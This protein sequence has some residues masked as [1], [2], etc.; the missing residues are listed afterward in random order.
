MRITLKEK[1]MSKTI[2]RD[3][4]TCTTPNASAKIRVTPEGLLLT[5]LDGIG[6][7][8][9]TWDVQSE[10]VRYRDDILVGHATEANEAAKALLLRHNYVPVRNEDA[11]VAQRL[12]APVHQPADVTLCMG[13]TKALTQCQRKPMTSAGAHVHFC[14]AHQ[15]QGVLP[16]TKAERKAAKKAAQKAAHKTPSVTPVAEVR[17]TQKE[18]PMNINTLATLVGSLATNVESLNASVL[19]Q[20]QNLAELT[21][22]VS[23]HMTAKPEVALVVPT[24]EI[25]EAHPVTRCTAKT[26]A[27]KRCKRTGHDGLCGSHKI[28]REEVAVVVENVTKGRSQGKKDKTPKIAK[29]GAPSTKGALAVGKGG[30]TRSE[31]NNA[32]SHK[33]RAAGKHSSGLS[34][35]RVVMNAWPQ[36]QAL[37]T[38]G[39]SVDQ[40]LAAFTK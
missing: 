4:L 24:V 31:W 1:I 16:P 2:A 25:A 23:G 27:G 22:L 35:Y 14:H 12:A 29:V 6:E 7:E 36:V 38:Q 39:K 33:A 26:V 17:T 13:L 3:A 15:A 30:L 37:R 20:G 32:L 10:D 40:V 5:F 19:A 34:V 8:M 18:I 9:G 28:A 21:A 11:Q